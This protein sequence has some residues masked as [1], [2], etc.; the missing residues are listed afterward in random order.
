MVLIRRILAVLLAATFAAAA[1]SQPAPARTLIVATHVAPP[2]VMK[3][4]GEWS[5]LSIELWRHIAEDLHLSYELRPLDSPDALIDAVASGKAGAAIAAITVTPARD[6]KVDFSQPYFSSGLAIA[7]P[8]TE[9]SGWR[10]LFL[11][12][13]SWRFLSVVGGLVVILAAAAF[14]VWLC[15]RRANPEQFGGG[16]LGGFGSAFWW[17]AVTMTTV[18]YGDKA[19]RT[20]GGR[21]IAIVWMFISVVMASSLTA[22]IA[23]SLT[24][25]RFEG[26]IHGPADLPRFTVATVDRSSA[27]DYLR[28]R[29]VAIV[30]CASLADALAAVES[31]KAEACVYD[32]PLLKYRIT[33]YSD[34]MVLPGTF[35]E[36]NYA[37]ALPLGSPLRKAVNLSLLRYVQS[38]SWRRLQTGY[39]GQP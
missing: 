17:S 7:V 25:T 36:R 11:A 14:G 39:L 13:F 22:H 4:D 1:R 34:L 28:S 24:L 32:A 12:F 35:E 23:S 3:S 33:R 21:A 29:E 15:E 37:I 38:E 30:P 5:G 9:E 27:A 8:A 26:R 10:A 16:G 19:P 2:F 31:G 20:A 18:G 6:L